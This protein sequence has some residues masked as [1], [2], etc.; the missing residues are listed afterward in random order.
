MSKEESNSDLIKIGIIG[1]ENCYTKHNQIKDS[2]FKIKNSPKLHTTV[3]V[4]GDNDS[5]VELDVKNICLEFGLMYKQSTSPYNDKNE[6]SIIARNSFY[7]KKKTIFNEILKY[8]I[9]MRYCD[10]VIFASDENSKIH[11]YYVDLLEKYNKKQKKI[12]II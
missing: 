1:P 7:N 12:I 5:G 8:D 6:Y 9:L 10:I 2:L 3:I 4:S 11:K